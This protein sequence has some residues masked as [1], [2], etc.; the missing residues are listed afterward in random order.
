MSVEILSPAIQLYEKSHLKRLVI[1]EWPWRSLKV[2][3]IS[4]VL[5]ALY[6]FLLAICSNNVAVLHRFRDM[7]TTTFTVYAWLQPWQVLQFLEDR[8]NYKPLALFDSRVNIIAAN[9]CYIFPEVWKS[10]RFQINRV[11]WRHISVVAIR[12]QF[13][14]ATPS[15]CV[16]PCSPVARPLRRHVQYSVTCAVCRWFEVQFESRPG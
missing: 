16:C 8:W 7:P 13:Y 12:S 6:Y 11:K 14:R 5:Q 3:R 9:T 4:G 15:Y 1:C 2:I 10:K